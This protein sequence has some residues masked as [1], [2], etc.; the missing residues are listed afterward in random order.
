MSESTNME[1]RRIADAAT[2]ANRSGEIARSEALVRALAAQDERQEIR[3]GDYLAET[4]LAEERKGSLRDPAIREWLLK[5]YI[6]SGVYAYSLA[7]TAFFDRIVEQAMRE[8]TPQIVFLGAGYDSRPYRF[9]SL[10]GE[11]RI[12]EL[13]APQTQARKKSLLQQA[14]IPIPTQLTWIPFIFDSDDLSDVLTRGGYDRDR[15]T[16]FVW[17][18]ITYTLSA[19]VVDATLNFIKSHAPATSTVCFDYDSLPPGMADAG[20]E[21]MK[22]L[23]GRENG[24]ETRRFGVEQGGIGVFLAKKDFM[25][26]EHLTAADMERK[27]LTLTDGSIAGS[28]PPHRCIVYAS[29]VG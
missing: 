27:F 10:L 19:E 1:D 6:P 26:L 25:I 20:P 22:E 17:E 5:N 14:A 29:V 21:E 11:T 24:G 28:V 23:M 8:K 16:L 15:Q 18:G 4:F 13:D 7:R 12:F 2:Y 9:A 3:G